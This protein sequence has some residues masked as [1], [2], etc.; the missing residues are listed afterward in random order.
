MKRYTFKSRPKELQEKDV[1]VVTEMSK[2]NTRSLEEVLTLDSD[3]SNAFKKIKKTIY[4]LASSL[5]LLIYNLKEV[6]N[7]ILINSHECPHSALIILQALARE[8]RSELVQYWPQI[9]DK[10]IVLTEQN[11]LLE[12]IFTCISLSLKYLAKSLDSRET[13]KCARPLISHKDPG[14][15]HLAAQSFAFVVRKDMESLREVLEDNREFAWE[16]A[17]FSVNQFCVEEVCEMSWGDFQAGKWLHL[18]LAYDK[19]YEDYVWKSC[20]KAKAMEVIRDWLLMCNGHTFPKDMLCDAMEFAQEEKSYC[21]LTY[22]IKYHKECFDVLPFVLESES[23]LECLKILI[24][25]EDE[26]PEQEAHER[27]AKNSYKNRP[28]PLDL[29]EYSDMIYGL[30][31]K[32]LIEKDVKLVLE[33][34]LHMYQKHNLPRGVLENLPQIIN[35]SIDN[36]VVWLGLHV[37]KTLGVKA[38]EEDLDIKVHDEYIERE[39][40]GVIGKVNELKGE[41]LWTVA[42]MNP[43]GID[44][45]HGLDDFLIHPALRIPTACLLQG[46][47]KLTKVIWDIIRDP[48]DLQTEK[49]IITNLKRIDHFVNESPR[50]ACLFF[51]GLFWERFSTIWRHIIL[52]LA[53]LAN[54]YPDLVWEEIIKLL[55]NKVFVPQYPDY[56]IKFANVRDW[57]SQDH[58]I[59]NLIEVFILCPKII[60]QHICEIFSVFHEF[61]DNEY[62]VSVWVPTFT[63]RNLYENQRP[64][65]KIVAFLKVFAACK[66]LGEF[67]GKEQLRKV[68]IGLC[69]EKNEEIRSLC[70]EGLVNMKGE[71]YFVRENLRKMAKEESFRDSFL[72]VKDVARESFIAL[73]AARAFC[74][75]QHSASALNHIAV[76][77]KEGFLLSLLPVQIDLE[78][79]K[80]VFNI[81]QQLSIS[82]LRNLRNILKHC[83][84]IIPNK[85]TLLHFLMELYKISPDKN[86]EIKSKALVC[87]TL[88]IKKYK[89]PES[90]ID[91][92]ITLI[93]H[94][95]PSFIYEIKPKVINLLHTLV[96]TYPEVHNNDNL[97]HAFMLI[98]QNEK[99]DSFWVQKALECLIYLPS[100]A[101]SD[102]ILALSKAF[103]HISYTQTLHSVLLKL[104]VLPFVSPLLCKILPLCCKKPEVRSLAEKWLP[105]CSPPPIN[106][107]SKALIQNEDIIKLLAICV[108]EPDKSILLKLSLTKQKGLITERDYESQLEA[109]QEIRSLQFTYPKGI[110]Y[111]LSHFLICQDLGVRTAA[112]NAISCFTEDPCLEEVLSK[113]IKKSRDEEQVR[114]VLQVWNKISTPLSNID[115]ERSLILN[116]GHLQIHRRVRAFSSLEN[117]PENLVKKLILP[118]ICFYLLY[119]TSKTN[120]QSSFIH[121]LISFLGQMS[122]V[123][124]WRGFYKQLK[125]LLKHINI[126][127]SLAIKAISSVLNNIPNIGDKERGVLVNKIL[128]K[129]K[130]QICDKKKKKRPKIRKYVAVGVF[131]ICQKLAGDEGKNELSRLLLI[132]SKQYKTN[133]DETRESVI[134]TVS[135]LVNAG[136]SQGALLK[137]FNH[138]L[139]TELFAHF[140]TQVLKSGIIT[141]TKDNLPVIHQVL[142]EYEQYPTYYH[143][144]K[145]IAPSLLPSLFASTKAL[146]YISQGLCENMQI[147]AEDYISIA[148]SLLKQFNDKKECK[149]K[150]KNGVRKSSFIIQPGAANGTRPIADVKTMQN[151]AEKVL[152]VRILKLGVK[153]SKDIDPGVFDQCRDAAISCLDLKKDEAV[154]GALEILRVVGDSSIIEHVVKVA[155]RAGDEIVIHAM[156]TLSIVIRN[157]NDAEN[158]ASLVLPQVIFALQSSEIQS[159]ALKLLRIFISHKILDELIYDAI[160][161]IPKILMDNPSLSSQVC[162][163]YSQFLLT[164]PLSEKRRNFHVDFL[165]K[166]LGCLNKEANE[167]IIQ[168]LHIVLDKFP[169]DELKDYYDFLL[170]SVVTTICNEDIEDYRLKYLKLVEKIIQLNPNS[171]IIHKIFSW[172]NHQNKN[173]HEGCIRIANI[174]L[175]QNLIPK[176]TLEEHVI[177]KILKS[178]ASKQVLNFLVLWKQDHEGFNQVIESQIK[179]LLQKNEDLSEFLVSGI[180]ICSNELLEIALK[181]IDNGSFTQ[182]IKNLVSKSSGVSVTKKVSAVARKMF[183]RNIEDN[184]VLELLQALHSIISQGEYDRQALMKTL[185]VFGRSLNTEIKEVLQEIFT[186]LHIGKTQEEFIREYADVKEKG[187]AVKEAKKQKF[188]L[189]LVSQPEVAVK[190]KQKRL[191]KSRLLK[192]KKLLKVA[193][194]KRIKVENLVVA[195]DNEN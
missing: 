2:E 107:L 45:S 28:Q 138:G 134:K 169:Y 135:E 22:M 187:R 8:V 24:D 44:V 96:L 118:L 115:P 137:E 26:H 73:C 184:R 7:V 162:T 126:E 39:L 14:I 173:L 38:G 191:K 3:T 186:E 131:K 105:V 71:E 194:Y 175:S 185:L 151:S 154:I 149:E 112:V 30:I 193:P 109:L 103:T 56:Y 130:A 90:E 54:T 164:Y 49:I 181:S 146:P 178:P 168:F 37:M 62:L 76:I 34:F 41:V 68:L 95:F 110:I 35:Q 179:E 51:I 78:G 147:A 124:K 116:L 182:G 98:L 113:C 89:Y 5:A 15:R 160:E 145:S 170:L 141:I 180:D 111:S 33:L 86:R 123:L 139:E 165:V 12:E 65:Q 4:H 122:G 132:I 136:C 142:L 43:N 183:G 10:L 64:L 58:F 190:M 188:K 52:G 120:Y 67:E 144:A 36:E 127:E 82:F 121:S 18:S 150:S 174:C 158:A 27:L 25:Y 143:I 172:I 106:E 152:A 104:P 99:S 129:L 40:A 153:K 92:I 55:K 100:C 140:L 72:E 31:D 19:K 83:F 69:T 133:D 74:K 114:S 79:A 59:K 16:I 9:L 1:R 94:H 119:S 60:A 75:S 88:S 163:L 17:K 21:V 97:T 157:I 48:A 167:G 61:F 195:K 11:F 63:I 148:L 29:S 32:F 23:A 20:K 91:Q 77:D 93:Q 57:V 70:V 125:L 42:E 84:N 81:P 159:S 80:E 156:K 102:M 117:P 128:P 192:K 176:K 189:M 46:K 13:L 101:D 171:P 66:G 47:S 161:E 177:D 50:T 85:I 87:I 6:V 108:P 166:N 53:N 155:E